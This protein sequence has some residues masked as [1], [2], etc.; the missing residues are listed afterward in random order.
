MHFGK[1]SY[2]VTTIIFAV[3]AVCIEWVLGYRRLKKYTRLIGV[4]VLIG[5]ASTVITES[6]AIQ[7]RAWLYNPERSFNVYI[8][9]AALET[10]IFAIFV[11]IAISSATLAWSRYEE[12]GLPLVETTFIKL[13]EKFAEWRGHQG[14]LEE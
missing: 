1:L 9:G 2:L 5:L 13:I 11:A 8:G 6:I 3:G 10:Y 14:T 4:V 12:Q 7:W